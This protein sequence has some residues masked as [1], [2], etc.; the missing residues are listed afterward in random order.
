MRLGAGDSS[1]VFTSRWRS[2]RSLRFVAGSIS[3]NRKRLFRAFHYIPLQSAC[4]FMHPSISPSIPPFVRPS[5]ASIPAVAGRPRPRIDRINEGK[6]VRQTNARVHVSEHTSQK[7]EVHLL[8]CLGGPL[9]TRVSW[10]NPTNLFKMFKKTHPKPL[11]RAKRKLDYQEV[12][13]PPSV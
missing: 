2:S 7:P 5:A 11:C 10:G 12:A 13:Q 6:K 8:S 1:N 9:V 3:N 4:L